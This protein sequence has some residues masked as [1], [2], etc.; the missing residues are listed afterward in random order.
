MKTKFAVLLFLLA[1]SPASAVQN[2]PKEGQVEFTFARLAFNMHG[3]RSPSGGRFYNQEGQVPWEHDY[4]S[5]EDLFL[6]MVDEATGVRTDPKAF[7]IVRLDSPEVF[8]YPFLYI[9]EP[10]FMDLTEKEVTNFREFFNRGGFAMYD[11]F[12]GNDMYN[13]EYE[14]K[15]VFPNRDFVRLDLKHQ[16]FNNYYAIDSLAMP[17]PYGGG[18]T[19]FWGMS[20]EKGRLIM[21]ANHNN[22]FGEFWEWVDKGQMPF[23]PAAQS[24]KFGVNYLIYAMTH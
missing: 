23:Q 2:K 8:K 3:G 14:M 18:E 4:P 11:D 22:D 21:I 13:L 9:S 5:S 24:F 7:Q 10:G 1:V 19:S 12:R 20:D 16:V 6:T 15:K 17:A